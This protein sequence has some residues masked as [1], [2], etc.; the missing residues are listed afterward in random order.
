MRR[1]VTRVYGGHDDRNVRL[2]GSIASITTDDTEN[3]HTSSLCFV[4]G[5]Y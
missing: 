2:F 5:A 1:Y 4:N 3:A